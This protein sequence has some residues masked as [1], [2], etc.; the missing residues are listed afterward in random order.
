M[1][2]TGRRWWDFCIYCPALA[3]I[4]RALSRWRVPRDQNWID[5]MAD[6]L[7]DFERLVSSYEST[8]R[9]PLPLAA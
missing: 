3:P 8:L 9:E 4:G 2:I 5:Q 6:D 1:W 7:V